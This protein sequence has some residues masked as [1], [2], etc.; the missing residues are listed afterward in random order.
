[1]CFVAGM[2]SRTGKSL[3][4]Y[5]IDSF[6]LE[7]GSKLLVRGR[8]AIG[9][10]VVH[11]FGVLEYREV[12]DKSLGRKSLDTFLDKLRS[13]VDSMLSVKCIML[14]TRAIPE[15]EFLTG[16]SNKVENIQPFYSNSWITSHNGLISNDVELKTTIKNLPP[17]LP[18]VDSAILPL[19]FKQVDNTSTLLKSLQGSY[20]ITAYNTNKEDYRFVLAK[21]FQPLYWNGNKGDDII[22][23]SSLPIYFARV[24][25]PAYSYRI[26]YA[27][28]NISDYYNLYSED[29]EDN[30]SVLVCLSSGLDSTVT[31]RLYQALGYKVSA[32]YFDYGQF[33][34]KLESH[35]SRRICRELGITRYIQ[36][37]SMDNFTSPLLSDQK[38]ELNTL[39]DAETTFSYVPQRNLIMTSYALAYAEQLGLGGV[40]LGM[41]L[42]DA[43]AYPDNGIPFL[44]KLNEITPYSSNW[45]RKLRATAPLVNLMK[46]EIIEIGLKIGVPFDLICSCY[47]PEL[48]EGYPVYCGQCGSDVHYK[49]AWNKLGYEPPN[50]G[51][52]QGKDFPITGDMTSKWELEDI[53]Y[54]WVIRKNL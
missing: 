43:G 40:A 7:T 21:N 16:G 30:K 22:Y 25:F 53:P 47:Y 9:A 45:N 41:N 44:N 42:S 36:K 6:L 31:L 4:K 54:N 19:L 13:V 28:G 26:W 39:A 52:E 20:A 48:E 5:L 17:D 27:Q 38:H 15:P 34:R 8:D 33:A 51:F 32:L 2:I 37:L 18:E 10:V 46:S 35:C 11:D 12:L 29:Q 14:Q 50:L 23:Y 3:D 24:E 1:M 49:N